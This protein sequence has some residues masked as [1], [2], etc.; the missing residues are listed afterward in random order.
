MTVTAATAAAA[1]HTNLL[2]PALMGAFPLPF[3]P[4]PCG[5]GWSCGS[6][7]GSSTMRYASPSRI[8]R[9]S[10]PTVIVSVPRVHFTISCFALRMVTCPIVGSSDFGRITAVATFSINAFAFAVE[11][12]AEP[13]NKVAPGIPPS[14]FTVAM[15]D[16]ASRNRAAPA[17]NCT[18]PASAV[19]NL[20]P[21]N[22]VVPTDAPAPLT[23]AP[24]AATTVPSGLTEAPHTGLI[25]KQVAAHAATISRNR[26]IEA[27]KRAT[28]RIL[29][30]FPRVNKESLRCPKKLLASASPGDRSVFGNT[31]NQELPHKT[32]YRTSVGS[33][34]LCSS[35]WK[36]RNR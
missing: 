21:A 11:N 33:P 4:A 32:T 1:Y 8:S 19:L 34:V 9:E 15:E 13:C 35:F 16:F 30:P 24:S 23:L 25:N 17:R 31:A 26:A 3:D 6:S 14:S 2:V 12:V 20:S 22:T 10:L 29:T 36:R 27:S 5:G 18:L 7:L 28:R